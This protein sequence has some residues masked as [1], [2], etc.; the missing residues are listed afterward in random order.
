MA[1]QRSTV[2]LDHAATTPMV[3]EAIEAMTAQLSRRGNPSSLHAAGR[4]ARRV[5][6]EARETIAQAMDCRPTEVIF[7]SGGTE[8]DNLAIVGAARARGGVAACFETDHHAA[9]EP[10]RAGGGV[11]LSAHGL[12]RLDPERVAAD[13]GRFEAVAVV[14]ICAVNNELGVVQPLAELAEAA[15]RGAPGALVHV[16]AVAAAAQPVG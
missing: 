8:A 6:E 15:R 11:A 4:E 9:I 12:G 5:V 16:D 2:Y 7:T 1:D 13:L 10:A 14:S 3:P